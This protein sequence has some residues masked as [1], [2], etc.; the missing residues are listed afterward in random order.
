MITIAAKVAAFGGFCPWR[1]RIPAA[2]RETPWISPEGLVALASNP[3][4][5]HITA[6]V[7]VSLGRVGPVLV[8]PADPREPSLD[9]RLVFRRLIPRDPITR[10]LHH[11]AGGHSA[12]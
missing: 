9:G 12:D 2:K 6:G 10:V 11:I 1:P 4:S 8:P 5:G 7:A 3:A